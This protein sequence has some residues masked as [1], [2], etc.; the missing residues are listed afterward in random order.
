MAYTKKTWT[1][2][3]PILAAD[4][5]HIEEQALEAAVVLHAH[6]GTSHAAFYSRSDMQSLFW[7]ESNDGAG[8]GLDAD[9]LSG[10]HV[11]EIETFITTGFRA[12]WNASNGAAPAGWSDTGTVDGDYMII[13]KD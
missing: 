9:K 13:Q 4:L 1:T 12:W 10:M 2:N 7:H 5:A 8:S 6:E 11:T 3:S